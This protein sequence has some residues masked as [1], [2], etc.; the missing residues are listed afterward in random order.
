M[1]EV[2]DPERLGFIIRLV[3][4]AV[5]ALDKVEALDRRKVRS[6][7]EKK[8]RWSG[9]HRTI[10]ESIADSQGCTPR[11]QACIVCI[12]TVSASKWVA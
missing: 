1:P 7:F 3:D 6:T 10:S 2:V 9:W 4:E 8:L 11:L 12:A 5:A